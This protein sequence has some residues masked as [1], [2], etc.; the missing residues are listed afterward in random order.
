MSCRANLSVAMD[1]TKEGELC[2][3]NAVEAGEPMPDSSCLLECMSGEDIGVEKAGDLP[4]LPEGDDGERGEDGDL[5]A[6]R[7][8]L[9]KPMSEVPDEKPST[10]GSVARIEHRASCSLRLLE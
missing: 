6:V 8:V 7:K 10:K 5:L 3:E 2:R 1:R 4:N 9:Q